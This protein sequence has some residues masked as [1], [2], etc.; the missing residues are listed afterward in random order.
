MLSSFVRNAVTHFLVVLIGC[1][2]H[3]AFIPKSIGAPNFRHLGHETGH[4]FSQVAAIAQD[5]KDFMWFGTPQGLYRFD[6]YESRE[7][8]LDNTSRSISHSSV[9]SL[10]VDSSGTVWVGTDNGLNRY[11][12][13]NDDFKRIDLNGAQRESVVHS[14]YE[15][16][17]KKVWVGTSDGIYLLRLDGPEYRAD[18][19]PIH[20]GNPGGVRAIVEDLNGVIYIGTDRSGIFK[21]SSG[22]FEQIELEKEFVPTDIYVRDLNVDSKGWVWIASFEN[23]V[24]RFNPE[25]G[26][27]QYFNES[28]SAKGFVSD[29]ARTVMQDSSGSVW[30]GTL[31][32]V[33]SYDIEKEQVFSHEN[34]WRGQRPGNEIYDIYEDSAGSLWLGDWYGVSIWNPRSS[35]FPVVNFGNSETMAAVLSLTEFDENTAL[36]GSFLGMHVW[37]HRKDVIDSFY[38]NGEDRV[39]GRVA[40][41]YRDIDGSVWVGTF[42]EGVYRIV[43]NNI[44]EHFYHDPSN[45]SSISFNGI[46][47]FFR[48]SR[49]RLWISTYGGGI[50]R[51]SRTIRSFVRYPGTNTLNGEFGDLRCHDIVEGHGGKLWIA[52]DGGGVT[53]LDPVTG[54]TE[55]I[56]RK[57][58]PQL[59]SDNIYNLEVTSA[60]VWMGSIDKGLFLVDDRSERFAI[61]D[62]GSGLQ[63]NEVFGL[64][65]D[66]SEN[67]WIAHP[68]G[69]ISVIT[70]FDE[71]YHYN[72]SHGVQ[73][74][75]TLGADAKLKDGRILFGGNS[76]VT[77]VDPSDLG[78]DRRQ[79]LVELTSFSLFGRERRLE[80]YVSGNDLK[81]SWTENT[82][83]FKFAALDYTYPERNQYKYKLEGFDRDWI[84]NGTNR[85]VTYT[86]LDPGSYV[87]RVQGSNNDGVFNT[88]GFTLPIVIK[89]PL[90]ATWWAY[91]IYAAVALYLFYLVLQMSARREKRFAEER[92]RRRLITYVESLDEASECV[93]NADHDGHIYFM[94]NAVRSVLGRSTSRVVGH[95]LFE[96]L[97]QDE[98]ERELAIKSVEDTGTYHA[99]IPFQTEDGEDKVIEVNI[100]EARMLEQDDLRYVGTVRDV[101]HRSARSKELILHNRSLEG[102]VSRLKSE[103]EQA[104]SLQNQAE[105]HLRSI[106]ANGDARLRNIHD[107]VNDNLQMLASIL[108]IQ[109]NK[110][111]DPGVA[112]LL[113]ENQER[114]RAVALVHEQLQA[115]AGLSQ[116]SMPGYLDSLVSGLVRAHRPEGINVQIHKKV[117]E[118]ELTIGQAVPC[119]LIVNELVANALI[120]GYSDRT[121]GS[122]NIGL[123]L[124]QS[125][126]EIVLVVSDDGKGLP[127]DFAIEAGQS[128]GLDIVSILTKQLD[129]TLKLV[130]GIGTTFEVRFPLSLND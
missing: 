25:S 80:D 19:I 128:M 26:E 31:D 32:G 23:G 64:K 3:A 104:R 56:N 105:D 100:N 87:L 73:S 40:S 116:V 51:F 107:R 50:N 46:T 29:R 98:N 20:M 61:Y 54:E 13:I 8:I 114:V 79:P 43:G 21:L 65:A 10:G 39:E 69:L 125:V 126:S 95:Q 88:E 68:R 89:P 93:L 96:L 24:I 124:Y 16:S 72:S 48:D 2:S 91:C 77:V 84:D 94:N 78:I 11:D 101:T 42:D 108:S 97:F 52:T 44:V 12:S 113:G 67:L 75:F 103:L 37:D 121:F 109:S 92:F 5:H 47:G 127:G 4:Q 22:E 82:L 60:G 55:V 71:V 110:I 118:V 123:E 86:N 99:D 33:Y 34:A 119:G 6:G 17:L 83:G 115:S 38:W 7:Y 27:F 9:W 76:G 28:S 74:E 81:L 85:T 57:S 18:K 120:H 41:L 122:A 111:N 70:S 58:H 63:R 49:N 45:D 14:I 112:A 62:V 1:I 102:D 66:S 106:V 15:D 53:V 117:S 59:L 90:W 129:G 35:Y 36:I 30:I 130:G